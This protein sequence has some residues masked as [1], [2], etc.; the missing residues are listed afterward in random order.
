MSLDISL[1]SEDGGEDYTSNI[2][3]NLGN[4]AK[5]LGI[6]ECLWHPAAH[7]IDYAENLI[8]PLSIAIHKMTEDPDEYRK[9]DAI[10]RWGTYEDFL[11]WLEDLLK[12][13]IENPKH[14]VEA[15]I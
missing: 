3:H 14:S 9:Y 11:P 5:A 12:A 7:N 8:E 2:T 15:F 1:V 13:C 4:M 10:N 6:Y